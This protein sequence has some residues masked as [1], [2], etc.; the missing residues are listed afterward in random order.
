MYDEK[1]KKKKKEESK[2]LDEKR[3]NEVVLTQ[4]SFWF[5]EWMETAGRLSDD[6][7]AI[8]AFQF[9]LMAHSFARAIYQKH[10][11]RRIQCK[12]IQTV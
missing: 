4:S 10:A 7:H 1:K 12:W 2:R 5:G 6:G 3:P 8:V 11:P 9:S